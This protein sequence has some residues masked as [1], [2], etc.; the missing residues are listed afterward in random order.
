MSKIKD[1]IQKDKVEKN[2]EKHVN[3]NT[4]IDYNVKDSKNKIKETIRIIYK[5]TKENKE[6]RANTEKK[7]KE[8]KEK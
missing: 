7:L 5:S 1:K 3:K 6:E 8:K 2:K 4:V